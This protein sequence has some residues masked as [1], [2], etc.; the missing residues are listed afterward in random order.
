LQREQLAAW[1]S[2]V[3]QIPNPVIAAYL[4]C[5][6]LTGARRE[7]LTGLKWDDVNFQWRGM[8]IKDKVDGIRAVPLTP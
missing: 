3:Q 7:E 5:L 2:H 6:L 8:S 1:F 4:Q